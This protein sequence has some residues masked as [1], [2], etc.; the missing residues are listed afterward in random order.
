MLTT[1]WAGIKGLWFLCREKRVKVCCEK[2]LWASQGEGTR[3]IIMWLKFHVVSEKDQMLFI[4]SQ[5]TYRE[6]NKCLLLSLSLFSFPV[7][8]WR[9]ISWAIAIA[10]PGQTLQHSSWCAWDAYVKEKKN[11]KRKKERS[12]LFNSNTAI[13]PYDLQMATSWSALT[14]EQKWSNRHKKFSK[15]LVMKIISLVVYSLRLQSSSVSKYSWQ[16]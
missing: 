14:K 11:K 1:T 6:V 4:L 8:E 15:V 12:S 16:L 5:Q 2:R 13:Q 10:H 7:H 3:K 9:W